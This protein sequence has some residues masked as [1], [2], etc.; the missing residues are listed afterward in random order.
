MT[1]AG[2]LARSSIAVVVEHY[3]HRVP[4]GTGRAADATLRALLD[5]DRFDFEGLAARHPRPE[6]DR[7]PISVAA[8]RLPRPVL[9]ESWHRVGRPRS[10]SGADLLWAPAMV[11]PPRSIPLVVTV[12]DLD[13]LKHPERL[14]RRG[15]SFFPRAWKAT[16]SRADQIV[17]PSDIVRADVIAA[18]VDPERVTTVPWGVDPRPAAPEEIERVRSTYDLPGMFALWV[19]TMEPRKNLRGMV[20]ALQRVDIPLVIVGP[21]GWVVDDVDL[22]APLGERALRLGRVDDDD[23]RAIY[24]AA[25]IFVF[26]SLAE[27]FG[28]PVLEAMAQSTVVVTS[29]GTATEE[30][31]GGA[32]ILVDPNDP[33]EIAD[34]VERLA[35]DESLRRDLERRGLAHARSRS[36][37][38]TAE[39]YAQVFSAVLDGTVVD[40]ER[41]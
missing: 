12:H 3:W 7:A 19:G 14:S 15:R 28:L 25:S 10:G 27:G 34:A 41:V 13:F 17:C 30:A 31:A 23:L 9:Y 22:F 4:G 20:D 33:L 6:R 26:P 8:S 37:R 5:L 38:G 32:A 36:W 40:G 24:A 29:R 11:V 18:G 2:D 35:S 39:G 16:T 21:S 1:P